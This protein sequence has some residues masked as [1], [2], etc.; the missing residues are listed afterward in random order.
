[1]LQ[2]NFCDDNGPIP[3]PD[4]ETRII[5]TR[6]YGSCFAKRMESPEDLLCENFGA[7]TGKNLSDFLT[8]LRT[9]KDFS[10]DRLEKKICFWQWL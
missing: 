6:G 9:I 2:K 8:N 7:S 10:K 4:I 1:M 3:F 5:L